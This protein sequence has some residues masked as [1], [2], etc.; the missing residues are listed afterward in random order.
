M[1]SPGV[2]LDTDF[3]VQHLPNQRGKNV[4]EIGTGTG[5]IA[6]TAAL[7][8]AANV[9]AVDI[10]KK[11]IRNARE[12]VRLYGVSEQVSLLASDIYKNVPKGLR[13]DT[14]MWNIPWGN[15]G[16]KRMNWIQKAFYDP[17]FRLLRRFIIEAPRYVRS[18]GKVLIGYSTSV[19]D[20][21]VLRQYAKKAG[22]QVRIIAKKTF[23]EGHPGGPL[24]VELFELKK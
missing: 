10:N 14:I 1:F 20:E 2:V 24:N 8:H 21:I 9:V 15:Y 5:L 23:K 6:I 12:N 4:L 17:G 7:Q 18:G 11:A 19:G 3:F 13:F 16:G 22:F